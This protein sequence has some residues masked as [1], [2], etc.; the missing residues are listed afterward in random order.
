M[1]TAICIAG[2]AG[3]MGRRLLAL[4]EADP[5]LETVQALE[6][7]AH[8]LQGK[9]LA[10]IEP[11]CKSSISLSSTLQPGADVIVDFSTPEGTAGLAATAA[12]MGVAMVIGTTGLNETETAAVTA[13]AE[14]IPVIHA[15]NFALGVNL[16]FRL[17]GEI[18]RALGE[19]F[20]IEIMEA[21]HNQK[22]D[23]PSGTALGIARSICAA[24]GRDLDRDLVHGRHGKPGARTRKEIGMHSLRMGSVVGDHTVHFGSEYER[25]ELTHRAQNRDVFAAGALRAAKWLVGRA[26]G[27]YGMAD[28]LFGNDE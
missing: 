19:D 27:S 6:S 8:P 5:E 1:S 2:A 23:A 9:E 20:D 24:T 16:V 7:A 3:R 28:V 14:K 17:A 12:E 26:A 10:D 13:A 22:A 18:A 15:P 21:H 25:I 4:A 11:A